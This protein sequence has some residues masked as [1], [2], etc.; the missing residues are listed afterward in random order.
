MSSQ[1]NNKSAVDVLRDN[2][3][4]INLFSQKLF[5]FA[6]LELASRLTALERTVAAYKEAVDMVTAWADERDRQ[7]YEQAIKEIPDEPDYCTCDHETDTWF[8]R[9]YT[10]NAKGECEGPYERCCECG[11]EKKALPDLEDEPDR[12][13]IVER[14]VELV[15]PTCLAGR[16]TIRRHLNDLIDEVTHERP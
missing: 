16:S 5:L 8:D 13:E 1:N 14:Y 3:A 12:A 9:S 10:I 11:K 2:A 4:S 7:A 6:I 15:Y